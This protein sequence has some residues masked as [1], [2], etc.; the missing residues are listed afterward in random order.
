[1]FTGFCK[2]AHM[3]EIVSRDMLEFR[4]HHRSRRNQQFHGIAARPPSAEIKGRNRVVVWSSDVPQPEAVRYA[5][6]SNPRNPNLTND[7]ALPAAP[8]RSDNWSGPTD[9]KR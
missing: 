6:N 3:D 1:M 4:D 8:F 7:T 2:K 9:G 5:F